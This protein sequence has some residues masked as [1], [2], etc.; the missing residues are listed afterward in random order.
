M[1]LVETVVVV[2]LYM[3]LVETV[4]KVQLYI[5]LVETVVVQLNMGLVETVVVVQLYMG[6]VETVVVVQLYMGL[7]ETVV[8]LCT[9]VFSLNERTRNNGVIKNSARKLISSYG[10]NSFPEQIHLSLGSFPN[11][12]II[13]WSTKL[14][15]ECFVEFGNDPQKL[16]IINAT[17]V[18]LTVDSEQSAQYVHRTELSNLKS[19]EHYSYRIVNKIA[20]VKSD[21]FR[22]HV[23]HNNESKLHSFLVVADMGTLT[24]SLQFMVHEA[25]NGNYEVVF[26][27]GDIAYNLNSEGGS[28]GDHYMN[29]VSKFTSSIPYLTTPGDHERFRSYYHYRYRFSMP[30]APWPMTEQSLWYSI[31]IGYTHFISINTEYFLPDSEYMNIQL[32]WLKKD[33][34]DANKFRFTVPWI[35][36]MGHKPVYCTKSEMEQEC[37]KENSKLRE[38]LEDLFYEYGVDLYISGHK[39]CYER[40]WPMYMNRPFQL[41]YINPVAPIHIVIG[42]MGYEYMADTQKSS[43]FWLAFAMSDSDKE[44]FARLN[45]VNKT[46]LIWSVHDSM[47]NEVVD[48]LQVIQSKHG[49]FGEPGPP[50]LNKIQFGNGNFNNLPPEPFHIVDGT[51]DSIQYRRFIL[52]FTVFTLSFVLF[53]FLRHSKVRKVIRF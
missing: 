21:I 3:G 6:L 49:S 13:M 22:F 16:K 53:L 32:E 7:V 25:L 41:N 1:G 24:K 51:Q 23:P 37:H 19:G 27:V 36:V 18:K 30:N 2:Q 17:K 39:H 20:H 12:I 48:D 5:G 45:V 4:V 46:H 14:D 42:A 28:I 31:N 10:M 38:L 26:H 40:T 52:F 44:L 15:E 34:S 9:S 8:V 50:A 43:P 35:I 29:R 11:N 47:T 33:L